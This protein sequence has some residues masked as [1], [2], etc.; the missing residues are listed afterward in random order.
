MTHPSVLV[1]NANGKIGFHSALLLA[2]EG[3]KVRALIGHPSGRSHLLEQAGV[4]IQEGSLENA[5]LLDRAFDGVQ[6]AFFCT[7]WS[8]RAL[9]A[10]VLFAAMAQEHRLEAVVTLSQWLADPTNPASH[11]RDTWLADQVFSWMPE[12]GAVVVNP[13]FF[14]DN[15]LAGLEPIAQ[16]GLFLMPLGEGLNAPP[17][18]E[19]IARV[20]AGILRNPAPHLGKTYRPTGPALLSPHDLASVFAKVLE[21]RVIYKD[22]PWYLLAK[23]GKA[24]GLPAYQLEQL[25]WY[26]REYQQNAFAVG[27]PTDVVET[28]GGR[29]PEDFESIVRRYASQS[30]FVRRTP[31][32]MLRALMGLTRAML[33]PLVDLEGQARILQLP[34]LPEAPLAVESSRWLRA[35]GRS[36]SPVVEPFG[37]LDRGQA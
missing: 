31:L 6:R 28:V 29:P 3:F 30:S 23:V 5:A 8:P 15:Y 26:V 21:R 7:P 24:I 22:V 14:A 2:H 17:S 10:S 20:V 25:R 12:V 27:G 32:S 4:E 18:N 35:R 11:T 16:F 36:A 37:A 13:G 33:T 1:A 9:S 19:D 34:R